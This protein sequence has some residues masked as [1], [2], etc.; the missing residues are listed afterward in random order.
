[1]FSFC[2]L[3]L[4]Q[5]RKTP[6][7]LQKLKIFYLT[8][9][10]V[11]HNMAASSGLRKMFT[12]IILFKK[13]SYLKYYHFCVLKSSDVKCS[14]LMVLLWCTDV[15]TSFG[16]YWIYCML[17]LYYL[18]LRTSISTGVIMPRL[19]LIILLFYFLEPLCAKVL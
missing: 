6:N 7:N 15:M 16:F 10:L 2:Y 18:F 4:V 11:L 14:Q 17:I 9:K 13:C 8:D 1:M 12:P 3:I 19:P 5:W